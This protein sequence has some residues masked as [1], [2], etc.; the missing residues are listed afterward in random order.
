[1]IEDDLY[2]AVIQVVKDTVSPGDLADFNGKPAIFKDSVA[3]GIG[4]NLYGL[5]PYVRI[6]MGIVTPQGAHK[7]SSW[8]NS[9]GDRVTQ[10][11]LN[12][13]CTIQ[14]VG[15]N[16]TDL[17]R[18]IQQHL[19]LSQHATATLAAAN[20]VSALA[21]PVRPRTTFFN[22]QGVDS[23]LF[24][25]TLTTTDTLVETDYSINVVNAD[26]HVRHHGSEDN[27]VSTTINIDNS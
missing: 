2:N 10:T 11:I 16:A 22:N 17:C 15:G 23:A 8:Y 21:D 4:K 26:L 6:I 27:I 18:K 20:T 25:C 3:K 14:V 1:M 24:L 7:H 5:R 19:M 12:V 13:D 9:D